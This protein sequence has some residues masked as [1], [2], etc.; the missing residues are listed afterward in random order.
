MR[1]TVAVCTWNRCEVL[2]QT[3]EQ[4]TRLAIPAGTEWELLVVNNNCTDETDEVIAA[5][6]SRLPIR[7]L[8]EPMPGKCN[9]LNLA[10]REARGE[11]ILWTDDDVFLDENWL[12][13]YVKAFHRWPGA[14][15]FGGVVEPWFMVPPPDWI[16]RVLPRIENVYSTRNLGSQPFRFK[17]GDCVPYGLNWAVKCAIQRRYKYDP[18][19]GPQPGSNIRGDETLLVWN[20]I[21]DGHE[22]W[23]VPD[24]IVRHR[25][26]PEHMQIQYLR[27]Y[28]WGYGEFIGTI[29]PTWNG[30]TL[31]G[32]PRWLWRQALIAEAKYRVRRLLSPAEVWIQDL[33]TASEAWGR[34]FP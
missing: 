28:F 2:R 11:Y 14:A 34:L 26:P 10:L 15:F 1:L 12:A 23:W 22:G 5:F 9:A 7:R 33:I 32:K 30:P 3:L 27:R 16:Q 18:R 4:M 8:F 25:I 6:M 20:L 29:E 19:V 17:G 31:F 24:A 21:A 13:A